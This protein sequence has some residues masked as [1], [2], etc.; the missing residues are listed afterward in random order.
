MKVLITGGAGYLGTELTYALASNINVTQVTVY[1]NMSRG[2]H[3]LF[4][5]PRK[6]PEHKVK[7]VKGDILDTRQLKK[8]MSAHDVV[9]HLAAKVTTPFADAHGHLYEQVNHW[10]TAEVVYAAE[11]TEL[12]Q[13]IFLSSVSVYGSGDEERSVGSPLDPRTYYGISKMRGEEHAMRYLQKNQG[14]IIRCG[15][16]YGY[17]KSMRFDALINRFLFEANFNRR[18]TINGN[19]EQCRAFVHITKVIDVLSSLINNPL[20]AGNYD[21]VEHNLSVNEVADEVKRI[22]PDLEMIFVN[23]HMQLRNVRVKANA[24]VNARFDSKKSFGQELD[25]FKDRFTF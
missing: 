21:L 3:N 16:V 12:E 19:G 14:C 25:E 17:S 15:N 11:E 6:M 1:D 13:L 20:S 2:N 24:D 18:I 10:G 5:G 22:F 9:Y 8:I 4:L 7:F 23:Q